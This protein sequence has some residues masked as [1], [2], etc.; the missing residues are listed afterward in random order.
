MCVLCP[1][2]P[3]FDFMLF[4]VSFFTLSSPFLVA[5]VFCFRRV[6]VCQALSQ[7]LFSFVACTVAQVRLFGLI[8]LLLLLAVGLGPLN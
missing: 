1:A 5:L 8:I 3:S 6:A 7:L 4:S 2:L